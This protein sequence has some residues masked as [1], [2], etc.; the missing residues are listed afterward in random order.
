MV[1]SVRADNVGRQRRRRKGES[2]EQLGGRQP[3]LAPR[4]EAFGSQS[5]G[6][7]SSLPRRGAVRAVCRRTLTVGPPAA[8]ACL[9][10]RLAGKGLVRERRRGFQPTTVKR[11]PGGGCTLTPFG[12]RE[13]SN[14]AAKR[15][16]RTPPGQLDRRQGI[17]D[18]EA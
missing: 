13:R 9:P 7:V 10:S 5:H 6:F 12:A 3:D 8:R 1:V 4:G 15:A 11:S 2:K 18:P 14:D 17:D 16:G